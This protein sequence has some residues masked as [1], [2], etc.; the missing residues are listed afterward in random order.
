MVNGFEVRQFA[1]EFC[2]GGEVVVKAMEDDLGVGLVE[3]GESCGFVQE[4]QEEVAAS[5]CVTSCA[6]VCKKK[7]VTSTI[8][9]QQIID[10][11]L[12]LVQI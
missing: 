2:D 8:F 5:W 6:Y 10:G 1:S 11:Q 12:L 4:V 7:S 9:L 3:L